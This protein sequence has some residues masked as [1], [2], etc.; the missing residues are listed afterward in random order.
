VETKRQA[1]EKVD[2]SARPGK[3]P[4]WK[5]TADLLTWLDSL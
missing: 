1:L 4:R 5:R 3:P 2:K